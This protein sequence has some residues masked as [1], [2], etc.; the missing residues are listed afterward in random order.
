[1]SNSLLFDLLFYRARSSMDLWR[2]NLEDLENRYKIT[3]RILLIKSLVV[4]LVVIILFFFSHFIPFVEL[5][6][7]TYTHTN[8]VYTSL[9]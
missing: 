9:L 4:L 7:G 2:K 5:N 1:M 6:L 3:D 8:T